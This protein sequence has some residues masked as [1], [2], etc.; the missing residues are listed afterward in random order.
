[1]CTYLQY[2]VLGNSI[3]TRLDTNYVTKNV[4]SYKEK[5]AR[6]FLFKPSFLKEQLSLVFSLHR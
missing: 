5:C 6:N 4:L 3:L 2:L 1:M